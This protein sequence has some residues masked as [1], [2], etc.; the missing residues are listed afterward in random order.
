MSI[1]KT[2]VG[3]S[4]TAP[5]VYYDGGTPEKQP[6][7]DQPK[8]EQDILEVEV[9][10]QDPLS[11]Q[12]YKEIVKVDLK[13]KEGREEVMNHIRQSSRFTAKMGALHAEARVIAN[14]MFKDF[15][16]AQAEQI[17]NLRDSGKTTDDLG[18]KLPSKDEIEENPKVLEEYF[19]KRDAVLLAKID[20]QNR[21]QKAEDAEDAVE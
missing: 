11:G 20:A 12:K 17:R 21:K 13:T 19:D 18:V 15:T 6:G 7:D 9:I 5:F 2:D 16:A 10:G 8:P 14:E 4:L 3:R 1:K